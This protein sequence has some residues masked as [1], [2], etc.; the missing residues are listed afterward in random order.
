MKVVVCKKYGSPEVLQMEQRPIPIPKDNEVC[1]K[2]YATAVTA[3]DSRIRWCRVTP[4]LWIPFRLVMW[5]FR[6]KREVLWNQ[7]A[8]IVESVGKN[9]SNFKV[10]DEIF[11]SSNMKQWAYAQYFCVPIS[12]AIIHKPKELSF[13]DAAA[14]PFGWSTAIFFLETLTNLQSWDK[15]M[16]NWAS[17][18]VG[19][20]MI[21]IAKSH[22]AHVTA[23]CSGKNKDIVMSLWA[24]VHIDYTKND[25]T[26]VLQSYD[27][28]YDFVSNL[29]YKDIKHLLT[30]KWKFYV[31]AWSIR[32]MLQKIWNKK[33]VSWDTFNNDTKTLQ[34]IL[35]LW[36]QWF[37]K[38][39][40]DSIYSLEEIMEAHAH[41]DT[42]R[43]VGNVV[44]NIDHS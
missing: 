28:I 24:D 26:Q 14:L 23:V 9:V 39:V 15:I 25:I 11:G 42:I 32:Q 20:N 35:V 22:W 21:Q 7:F 13:T 8:W 12:E 44:I 19:T 30:E 3:A 2:N 1:V 34:R 31:G 40:I 27:Y 4:D 41:V 10:G 18:C 38:P 33:V 5:V 37:L 43:K 36:R 17:G 29:W 6:P 16:I